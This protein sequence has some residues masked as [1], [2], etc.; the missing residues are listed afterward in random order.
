MNSPMVTANAV[1]FP[2]RKFPDQSLL[3]NSPRHIAAC[4]VLHRLLVP[5]H[6]PY[7]L[8]SL[9]LPLLLTRKKQMISNLFSVVRQKSVLTT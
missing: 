7:A 1:G 3:G 9:L 2:I 5:R 6:P 8:S 4:H